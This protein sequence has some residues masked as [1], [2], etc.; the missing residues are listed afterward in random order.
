MICVWVVNNGFHSV[1]ANL[2]SKTRTSASDIA[3]AHESDTQNKAKL[4][5]R[6]QNYAEVR[7]IM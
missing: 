7:I 2:N 3:S 4:C 5:N 6:Q 1:C